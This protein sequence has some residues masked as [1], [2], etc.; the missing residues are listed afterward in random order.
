MFF[1]TTNYDAT[2]RS[3]CYTFVHLNHSPALKWYM[4]CLVFCFWFF[5]LLFLFPFLFYFLFTFFV[6]LFLFCFLFTVSC[7]QFVFMWYFGAL[8]PS[9]RSQMEHVVLNSKA[10]VHYKQP[11]AA[12]C[13]N[14]S[15]IFPKYFIT[16]FSQDIWN[17]VWYFS[18]NK[19]IN[20]DWSTD[21]EKQQN[22]PNQHF[23]WF[24]CFLQIYGKFGAGTHLTTKSGIWFH[25]IKPWKVWWWVALFML[26]KRVNYN[27]SIFIVSIF[28]EN[29]LCLG[30]VSRGPTRIF[31]SFIKTSC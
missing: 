10:S 27:W 15:P 31:F 26:F 5:L 22:L 2:D 14:T 11:G 18:N 13:K 28:L 12:R 1:R 3:S 30:L 8:E 19:L 25:Q 24:I 7:F 29:S 9:I 17:C 23:W 20:C 21:P 16:Y 6:F 4:L